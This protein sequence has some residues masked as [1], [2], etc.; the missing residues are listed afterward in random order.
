M[1]VRERTRVETAG[2]VERY[3]PG[4]LEGPVAEDHL[5]RYQYACGF[6]AQRQVVDVACG[7]GYGSRMMAEA[8]AE[9]V[10]GIDVCFR[11]VLE[12]QARYRHPAVQFAAGDACAIALAERSA[13][14]IVSFET[15]E[16]VPHPKRFLVEA[17]RLLRPGG[18][19]LLSTPNRE[20]TR[21]C[22]LRQRWRRTPSNPFHVQEFTRSEL[23]ALLRENGFIVEETLGQRFLD[24][25]YARLPTYLWIAARER[26]VR[27]ALRQR[28][29][30][31]QSSGTSELR[32]ISAT[33]LPLY[34]VLFCRRI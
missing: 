4:E 16:H 14:V 6:V 18:I 13:D 34:M 28:I 9:R 11:T 33:Q 15:F 31:V 23:L 20:V 22:G 7:A 10:I 19:L 25:H 2:A 27:D 3:V 5:T 32:P 1:S 29:Y 30:D 12:A 21:L 26:C 8:G 24:A 17:R